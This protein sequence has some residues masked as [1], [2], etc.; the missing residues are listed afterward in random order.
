MMAPVLAPP[1]TAWAEPPDP[2][3]DPVARLQVVIKSVYIR[4]DRDLVGSGELLLSASIG[5]YSHGCQDPDP[6]KQPPSCAGYG[7]VIAL[8]QES[9]SADSK[10][11]APLD[12]VVP[13]ASDVQDGSLA[14][15]G[16]GM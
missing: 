6:A 13:G 8:A 5:R 7:R 10:Q 14:S 11:T 4:D 16:T 12:R 1:T 2:G 15:E 9:F 3:A